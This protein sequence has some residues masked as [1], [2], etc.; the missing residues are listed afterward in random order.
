MSLYLTI[1]LIVLRAP[2]EIAFCYTFLGG[3]MQCHTIL[4]WL[5]ALLNAP[6]VFPV[7]LISIF[8]VK[9]NRKY[10]AVLTAP[11]TRFNDY[12]FPIIER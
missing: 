2:V 5:V 12:Y 1:L 11:A 9:L 7:A 4:H 10:A 8:K 6:G 3:A